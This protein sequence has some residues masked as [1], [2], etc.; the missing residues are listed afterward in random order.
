LRLTISGGFAVHVLDFAMAHADLMPLI[1]WFGLEREWMTGPVSTVLNR[2]CN[3]ESRSGV[4]LEDPGKRV[5]VLI[6]IS[7]PV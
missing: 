5:S 2:L 4:M 6:G 3:D 1:A 7:N